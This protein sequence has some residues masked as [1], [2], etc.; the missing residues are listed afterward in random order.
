MPPRL[1]YP[2]LAPEGYAALSGFG[3]YVNTATALP[4]VLLGLV[5]LRASLLNGCQ[6][7]IALHQAEL[8]KLHEPDSRINAVAHGPHSDAFTLKEQAVLRWTELLTR[9]QGEPVSDEAYADIRQFFHDKDLVDLTFAI[10]NINA[11]NRMGIAFQPH[12]RPDHHAQGGRQE[13]QSSA[14]APSSQS[15]ADL[16]PEDGSK[17]FG[18]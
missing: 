12:F 9:L 17:V 11:W 10:A 8:R 13:L 3:H 14:P 16:L 2:A 5:Y 15:P 18:K 7:C 1:R 4:P 6:F